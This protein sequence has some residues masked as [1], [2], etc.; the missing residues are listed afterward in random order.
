MEEIVSYSCLPVP[1]SWRHS[2]DRTLSAQADLW[3]SL[4]F[5]SHCGMDPNQQFKFLTYNWIF[6]R[7]PHMLLV[8]VYMPPVKNSWVEFLCLPEPVITVFSVL[9]ASY[10]LFFESQVISPFRLCFRPCQCSAK[11]E[12]NNAGSTPWLICITHND[13][14]LP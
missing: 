7:E 13:I 6:S 5:S 4:V 1:L 11:E 12:D 9:T 14:L 2:R 10:C 3:V 8:S